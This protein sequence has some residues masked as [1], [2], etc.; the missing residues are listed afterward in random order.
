MTAT[1]LES[2]L[3]KLEATAVPQARKIALGY[4]GGLDSALCALLAKKQYGAEEVLPI[5]VDVGQGQQP[6]VV[7]ADPEGN[8][9]CVLARCADSAS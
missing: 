2:A 7:L 6:W 8:E 5:L 3:G 1:I 9:F 4:A